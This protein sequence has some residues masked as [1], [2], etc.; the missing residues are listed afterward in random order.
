MVRVFMPISV[1]INI[2]TYAR[3]EISLFIPLSP[4]SLCSCGQNIPEAIKVYLIRTVIVVCWAF[5]VLL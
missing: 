1:Q 2:L 5:I 3:L 4:L